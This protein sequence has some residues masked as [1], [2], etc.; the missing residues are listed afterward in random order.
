[1][2]LVN[3]QSARPS[4]ASNGQKPKN[5]LDRIGSIEFEDQGIKILLY[6]Q[7]G[8]GKTTCWATFP[9][10]ILS[11]ICSGG[12][13][14]GEL[15]SVNTAEYRKKIKTVTLLESSEIKQ[16]VEAVPSLGIKTLVLDHV[17]GLADLTLKEILGLEELPAQKG[18]G[19]ASMAQYGQCTLQCKEYL[20]AMLN[21]TCNVVIIGQER[22]FGGKEDGGDSDIIKPTV[23]VAV[24]PSL[25]GWLGPAVDYMLQLYKRPKMERVKTKI[26]DKEHITERR[27]HGVEYCARCESHDVYM[28]KFRVPMGQD[29]PDSIVNPTYDKIM[30]AINGQ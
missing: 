7:S 28:T 17:S 24:S 9:G 12:I 21:L 2:P 16:I 11:V 13:R 26:G 14:P 6:G 30:K 15:R 25:A 23:G 8:S 20:R 27:G 29:I 18:F 5:V 10:P 4:A 19:M 22:T 1:M 3:K